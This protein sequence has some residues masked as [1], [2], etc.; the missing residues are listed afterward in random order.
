MK[1]YFF[2]LFA[3]SFFVVWCAKT[4]N[5]S[6]VA[7]ITDLSVLQNVIARVSQEIEQWTISSDEAQAMVNQLQQ[8]YLELTDGTQEDIENSFAHI[9]TLFDTQSNSYG[10]PFWAKKL[11]MTE[12]KGM[13]FDKQ[14]SQKTYV[15]ADGYTS[16]M[17]VYT[18]NYTFAMQQAETIAKSANLYVSKDFERAQSLVNSGDVKYISWLDISS[19]SAWIIYVNHE[20]LDTNIDYLLSVSVDQSWTL[21]I[22]TTKYADN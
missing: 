7:K 15:N 13:F 3:F 8:K 16:T 5:L 14:H 21:I 20:L 9:Q 12:P 19:L 10:L 22:E 1:K 6:E 18:W 11:W 17:L 2:L 4:M